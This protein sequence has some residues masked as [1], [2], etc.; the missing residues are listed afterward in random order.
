MT[1]FGTDIGALDDIDAN[2][3]TV[4]DR[5]AF[6]Q[7]LVRR[8]TTPRGAL[9]YAQDYGYDV[10]AAI[11]TATDPAV[12][13]ANAE[14][15]LLRDERVDDAEVSLTV[16]EPTGDTT[17]GGKTWSLDLRITAGDEPYAFTLAV[18]AVTGALLLTAID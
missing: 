7:A 4:D 12:I 17:T 3:T 14:A 8:I 6:V 1:D 9:W 18:D 13:E 15:E 10:T 11:N 5:T 2:L 16:T